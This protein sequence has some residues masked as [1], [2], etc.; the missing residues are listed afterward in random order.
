MKTDLFDQLHSHHSTIEEDKAPEASFE[1][2]GCGRKRPCYRSRKCKYCVAR[3]RKRLRNVFTE[4]KNKLNRF[5]TATILG[6]EVFEPREAVE[7]L[8]ELR[9]AA[10]KGNLKRYTGSYVMCSGVGGLEVLIAQKGLQG[11]QE[12]IKLTPHFHIACEKFDRNRLEFALNKIAREFYDQNAYV[13]FLDKAVTY[14]G[15]LGNYFF[16]NYSEVLPFSSSYDRIITS[17]RDIEI[18]RPK[19]SSFN[20]SFEV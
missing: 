6:I 3:Y 5:V 13:K 9:Y 4:N 8:T 14:P 17:S 20:E 2:S 12:P 11:P 1:G 18:G 10:F 15:G 7:F 16:Q 19:K